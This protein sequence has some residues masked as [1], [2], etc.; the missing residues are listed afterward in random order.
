M[1]KSKSSLISDMTEYDEILSLS[2]RA[3]NVINKC[4]L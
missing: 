1:S 3:E 4:K 2:L